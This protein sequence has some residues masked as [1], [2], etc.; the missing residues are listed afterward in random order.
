[1]KTNGAKCKQLVN[2]S[3]G[4]LGVLVLFLQ[5]FYKCLKL[6]PKIYS[7]TKATHDKLINKS[8]SIYIKF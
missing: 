3:E 6:Y 2:L 8:T 1:M 4:Y 7:K 5:H